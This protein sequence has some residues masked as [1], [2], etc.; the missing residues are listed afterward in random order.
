MRQQPPLDAD[1]QL[2]LAHVIALVQHYAD[3]Q[4]EAGRTPEEVAR[5]H[6]GLVNAIV[7]GAAAVSTRMSQR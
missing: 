6:A 2:V 5:A 7:E 4:F 3:R 1:T